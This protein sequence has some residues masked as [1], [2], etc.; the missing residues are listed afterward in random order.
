MHCGYFRKIN[1]QIDYSSMIMT[2]H[3]L[4]PY[5]VQVKKKHAHNYENLGALPIT[6]NTTTDF[7]QIFKRILTPQSQVLL[8]HKKTVSAETI[9]ES[10]GETAV[11]GTINAGEFG[12][13]ADLYN[14]RQRTRK[15]QARKDDDSEEYPFFFLFHQPRQTHPNQGFLILS[16][17]KKNGI[18]T[19]LEYLLQKQISSLNQDLW[20]K[21]TPLISADLMS[22]IRNADKVQEVKFVAHEVSRDIADRCE[23]PRRMKIKEERSFIARTPQGFTP[24]AISRIIRA[25]R[26]VNQPMFEVTGEEYNEIKVLVKDG[27][28]SRTLTFGEREHLKEVFPL[29]EQAI[30]IMGG[31]PTTDSILPHARN[32]LND[33]LRKIEANVVTLND[34]TAV[35]TQ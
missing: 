11:W 12:I 27:G 29:E 33:F 20:V 1:N 9:K 14:M 23:L 10:V 21:I 8:Q 4:I 15:R 22:V 17:F 5:L 7:F 24:P 3:K 31:F 13:T 18:K 26:N 34:A 2:R 28:S 30:T 35:E 25:F 32:Y 19:I 6:N 16:E